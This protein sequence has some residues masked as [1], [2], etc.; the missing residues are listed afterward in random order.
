MGTNRE[1]LLSEGYQHIAT[2]PVALPHHVWK[3]EIDI[4]FDRKLRVIEEAVLN[5][6]GAGVTEPQF[7]QKLLGL[8]DE[9]IVPRYLAELMRNGLVAAVE[10]RLVLTTLGKRSLADNCARQRDTKSVDFRH[11][12]Y[13]DE[14]LWDFEDASEVKDRDLDAAGLVAL[15]RPT[16]LTHAQ[17][18][19]RLPEL[20]KLT[21]RDGLPFEERKK[22]KGDR[23]RRP[24]VLR[25]RPDKAYT[26][27]RRAELE[28]WYREASDEWRW[29]LFMAGGEIPQASAKLQ[30]MEADGQV[31]LPVEDRDRFKAGPK[32]EALQQALREVARAAIPSILETADHRPALEQAIKEATRNLIIISP[33]IRTAAVDQEML[34]WF[35]HGMERNKDLRI[36][37]GYG[38]EDEEQRDRNGF[39]PRKTREQE[40]AISR[41]HQV[42]RQFKGR[43]KLV[44]IGNTHEKIVVVDERY[45]IVT[46]F[47]FLSFNPRPGKAIRRE[48]G[49]R[50]S[51]AAEVKELRSRLLRILEDGAAGVRPAP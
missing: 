32:E 49:Y 3:A 38:I 33:W 14:F 21:E 31:I 41:L 8:Q 9:P 24:E 1:S 6:V 40:E 19:L 26:A 2:R 44:K 48:T 16:G 39:K 47:N 34:D 30:E 28:I 45:A 18:Q 25:V 46:S 4:E 13:R 20:Q 50:L 7:I 51:G 17:V 12:P 42:S 23:V 22:P 37:I 15:P 10:D 36:T 35:R 11:D 29:L 43:L 27:Y 5:L